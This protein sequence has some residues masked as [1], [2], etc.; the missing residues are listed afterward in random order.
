MEKNHKAS[1]K[2]KKALGK[3]YRIARD[4]E[5]EAEDASVTYEDIKVR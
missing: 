2:S 1:Y 4:Y 5:S 3:M